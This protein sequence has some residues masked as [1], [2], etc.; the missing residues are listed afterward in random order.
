MTRPLLLLDELD[1]REPVFLR[2]GV[3]VGYDSGVAIID[4]G[5]SR[6]PCEFAGYVPVIGETVQVLSVGSRHTLL[7]LG[8]KPAVGTVLTVSSPTCVVQTVA[9]NIPCIIGGTAPTSGD[10]VQIFWG[11]DGPTTGLKLATT[12]AAP[13]P[14]PNPGGGSGAI[15][16]LVFRAVDA[17]ST[18]RGSARWWQAQPW[19]SNTT[20]GAWFFGDQ[21]PGSIPLS[22]T[23]A[24]LD[25]YVNRVQDSGGAPN[26]VPHDARFKAGLPTFGPGFAWDP[27]NGWQP[28]PFGSDFFTHLRAGGGIGLNQGG[29]NKFAS[30][31]QDSM[32]G[33]VRISWRT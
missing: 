14:P 25:F 3:Y 31:A 7:P 1:D 21:I 9:G 11:E 5:S 4:M 13:E 30:L 2:R 8:A 23:F 15:H 6:F 33:A 18:D 32:S 20:Y 19:A 16:T 22:A 26:F 24:G 10:R 27:P 17:G 12:A 29:F 28:F